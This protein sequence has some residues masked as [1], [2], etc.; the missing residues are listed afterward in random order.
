[1]AFAGIFGGVRN[2]SVDLA[3]PPELDNNL[4]ELQLSDGGDLGAAAFA[5]L[6]HN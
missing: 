2:S 5:G 4:H 3:Q 6:G 1:M